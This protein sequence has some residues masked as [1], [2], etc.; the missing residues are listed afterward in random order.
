MEQLKFD[1]MKSQ[2]NNLYSDNR[3]SKY[4]KKNNTEIN[5]YP[6]Y[7]KQE[8]QVNIKNLNFFNSNN[9]IIQD[10]MIK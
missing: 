7:S 9:P 6:K 5:P 10:I 2:K 4:K 3:I 1:V 8:N